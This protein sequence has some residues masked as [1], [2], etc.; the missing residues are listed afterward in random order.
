MNLAAYLD[1]LS[2]PYSQLSSAEELA[3]AFSAFDIDDS[4]QIDVDDL[5]HALLR[6]MP[7]PGEANPGAR[8]SEGDVDSVL[9][10]FTGR[11]AFGS[12]GYNAQ[13]SGT[14]KGDVFRWRDFVANLNGGS[15][16]RQEVA[17]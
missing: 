8:L 12:R 3:A 1:S 4:G 2:A 9:D 16:E 15:E 7:E 13:K 11:R 5:R 10:S 14:A 17:V 6:T